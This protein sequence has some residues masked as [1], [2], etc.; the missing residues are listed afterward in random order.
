MA[1]RVYL[2]TVGEK[3]CKRLKSTAIGVRHYLKNSIDWILCIIFGIIVGLVSFYLPPAPA[4]DGI[5]YLLSAISQALAAIFA[6]VFTITLMAASMARKYTAIDKFFNRKTKVLMLM[7]VIGIVL[8]LLILKLTI[9]NGQLYNII[10]P[11][12]ML[13]LTINYVQLYNIVLSITISLAAFCI[14]AI[15]PYLRSCNNIIKFE[16]GIPNLINDLDESVQ[17]GEYARADGI[18]YELLEIGMSAIQEKRETQL[19]MINI[20]I[21]NRIK[22]PLLRQGGILRSGY[23]YRSIVALCELGISATEER[24]DNVAAS[25]TW[26]LGKSGMLVI[27][28]DVRDGSA[29]QVIST[30]KKIGIAAAKHESKRTLSNSL[31]FLSK[32]ADK[33]SSKTDWNYESE[34]AYECFGICAAHFE[35]YFPKQIDSVCN[36]IKLMKLNINKDLLN[37]S[38]DTINKQYPDVDGFLEKFIK[39]L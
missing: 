25:I 4:N 3:Q 34:L 5:L 9:N 19:Y 23:P 30:L 22:L 28:K 31:T 18:M 12:L 24:M 14:A 11:L 32:L 15:I 13:K 37:K 27:D 29:E 35:K 10:L 33:A 20:G 26:A 6:L 39:R 36:E 16:M 8:P 7:F 17:S 38:K 2:R 1:V 21:S